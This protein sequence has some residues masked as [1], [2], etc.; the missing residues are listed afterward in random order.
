MTAPEI[1][2]TITRLGR[3]IEVVDVSERFVW[4]AYEDSRSGDP[5][6]LSCPRAE[7]ANRLAQTEAITKTL[8]MEHP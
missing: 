1:G 4:Y 6:T 7:W 8:M 2:F 3:R 5:V